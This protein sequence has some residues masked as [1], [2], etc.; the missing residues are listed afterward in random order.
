MN[1]ILGFVR[2]LNNTQL[3]GEQADYLRT[4]EQS[5]KNLLRII[6]DVLDLSKIEAGKL[7]ITKMAFNLRECIEDVEILVSPSINEKNL[8]IATLFYD[9]TPELLIAP[10]DRIRQILINLVGNAIK[11]S[12]KGIIIIRAMLEE[13]K[14]DTAIIKISVSDQGSGISAKNQKILFHSFTQLDESDTRQYGGAGLG[15][16]ISK[17]LAKAMQG[18][19][20]VESELNKGSTFWFTFECT[21]PQSEDILAESTRPFEGKSI[22]IYD[23]NETSLL[24]IAHAFRQ[25]GFS[26]LEYH[27]INELN[28]LGADKNK[29]DI[30]VLNLPTNEISEVAS[31]F[32]DL[33]LTDKSLAI[34]K[35]LTVDTLKT[36]RQFN[37]GN[38]LSR[39]FR[40]S[41]LIAALT[42]ITTE[43][44]GVTGSA[45]LSSASPAPKRLD[46]V[47]I[48]V[49][50]DNPIN[51]KFISTIL[52]RSGADTTI[53]GDGQLAVDEFS[54]KKFDAIL[55]DIHMP[56][57]TGIEATRRIRELEAPDQRIPILGLTAI[58]IGSDKSKY[59]HA[60]LDEVLEK[61]IAVDELLHEIA[62]RVHTNGSHSTDQLPS[63]SPDT[64][65]RDWLGVDKK[66][67]CTM[68]EM[69]LA[70]LPETKSKLLESNSRKDWKA[71]RNELHRFLG[72]LSYC[73]IPK[74]EMLTIE[75]QQSLKTQDGKQN[76]HFE[77]LINEIDSLINT[78]QSPGS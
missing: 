8:E 66:L 26:I 59:N 52:K 17:S 19:I 74:L 16:S 62:Y 31:L 48:L 70:E 42:V 49:A 47:S 36:L 29:P 37:L 57:M 43:V 40:T 76:D 58:K 4:I 44:E 11:F 61:P 39:P 46:G 54:S 27:N 77:A 65:F 38:Y 23:Q 75:F 10:Q 35:S 13:I 18:D 67:A 1:G 68:N 51:A 30:F 63:T 32:N 15:L 73:N 3:S 64:S 69:L 72:G 50:E 60:G 53:V 33:E 7:S 78:S 22:G 25:L 14:G 56:T 21:I 28:N 34:V 71:L 55:M 5:A 24:C 6:N 45:S 41:D 20:G 9:D 2:L 12:D